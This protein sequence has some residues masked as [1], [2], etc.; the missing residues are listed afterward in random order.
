MNV[1]T[2]YTLDIQFEQMQI[3]INKQKNIFFNRFHQEING[4]YIYIYDI[5]MHIVHIVINGI[6]MILRCT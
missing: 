1:N 3:F 4:I 5:T 6:Y 2:L